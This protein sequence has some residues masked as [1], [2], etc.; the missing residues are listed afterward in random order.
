MPWKVLEVEFQKRTNLAYDK[1]KLKNKWDWMRSRWSLWKALKGK[2][3][4]IVA[5]GTL[6]FTPG[7]REKESVYIPTPLENASYDYD[8]EMSKNDILNHNQAS[9][10]GKKCGIEVVR[11]LLLVLPHNLL[12]MA[13]QEGEV[14]GIL[15]VVT[16]RNTKEM[17]LMNLE[18]SVHDNSSQTLADS[19]AKLVSLDGLV[20]DSLEFSFACTLIEDPQK[21]IIL[22]GMPN[23]H[24]RLQWIKFLYAKSEKN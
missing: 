18:S 24:A 11:I 13:S 2:E 17:E 21:R 7:Q 10:N 22:D 16:E 1:N 6:R 19:L 14:K 23:D 4:G 15:R 5:Q 20:P 3:T 12:N 9:H 8:D